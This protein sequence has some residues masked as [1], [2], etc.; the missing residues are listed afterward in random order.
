MTES[1]DEFQGP[2]G[3]QRRK[4]SGALQSDD[5]DSKAA[6]YR[7]A[8]LW[9]ARITPVP[10]MGQPVRLSDACSHA[11]TRGARAVA[12]VRPVRRRRSICSFRRCV[13]TV[14]QPIDFRFIGSRRR[15][16]GR[17]CK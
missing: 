1:S 13:A 11:L 5:D 17:R 8:H 16:G 10:R 9:L 12:P 7:L 15:V 2:T 14:R 6:I 4:R 3:A